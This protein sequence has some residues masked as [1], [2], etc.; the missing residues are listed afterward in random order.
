MR[1]SGASITQL[2]ESTHLCDL[3]Q[4]TRIRHLH[5]EGSG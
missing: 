2:L 3:G 5:T 4:P 1:V